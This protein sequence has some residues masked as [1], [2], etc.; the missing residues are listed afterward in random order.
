MAE[1]LEWT[2][3]IHFTEDEDGTRADAKLRTPTGVH[4]L[5]GFGRSRR[6]RTEPDVRDIGDEIAAAR[7]LWGL[8]GHIMHEAAD[9]IEEYKGY[10]VGLVG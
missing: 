8:A 4:E 3:E 2:V 6:K 10:P 7:A 1:Q 5:S 9:Q